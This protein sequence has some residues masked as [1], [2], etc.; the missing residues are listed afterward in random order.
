[1]EKNNAY[2]Y[3]KKKRSNIKNKKVSM[4]RYI[5]N[6]HN[7]EGGADALKDDQVSLNHSLGQ[8]TEELLLEQGDSIG[9]LLYSNQKNM[10]PKFRKQTFS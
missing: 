8:D 4:Q 10:S 6:Y 1:M 5:P 3:R 7:V 2:G 9:D